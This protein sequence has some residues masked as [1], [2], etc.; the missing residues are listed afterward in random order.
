MEYVHLLI[1]VILWRRN[2][3]CCSAGSNC[4]L[5]NYHEIEGIVDDLLSV[6]IWLFTY[7]CNPQRVLLEHDRWNHILHNFPWHRTC[8]N[9]HMKSQCV[10]LQQ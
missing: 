5:Q 8:E 2:H 4:L 1:I 6:S 7:L 10:I 9:K 3:L